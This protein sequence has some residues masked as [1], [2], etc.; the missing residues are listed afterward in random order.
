MAL[1]FA[2]VAGGCSGTA[3]PMSGTAPRH[4]TISGPP[5]VT[6]D[7]GT[8]T[9]AADAVP[10]TLNDHTV[11]GDTPATR[12]VG[13]L[14]W[15]QVFQVAPGVT[16]KLDTAVVD[17]AEVVSVSPQ[18]VVYHIDPRA[19]WSDGVPISAQ[20]FVYAWLAQ[21]GSGQDVGGA[22]DSVAS[23][24]G[25][26]D[27]ASVVGSDGGRTVTV[28]FQR[29]YADWMSLFDDLLPAHVAD[30]AGWNSGFDS[31]DPSVLVSGGPFVVQAWNP[32]QSIVLARNPRWWGT[33]AKLDE[34]VVRALPG[35]PS[36]AQALMTGQAQ[37]A[38]PGG[39]GADLEATV[40]SSPTLESKLSLGT[41]ILQLV[42]DVHRA[43]LDEATV[44]QGIAHALDRA[45]IASAL[46][47]PL[48]P[49]TWEANDHLFANTEPWYSDDAAGYEEPDPAAAAR[50]LAAGGLV[51]D[52]RG[53]WTLH[54]TP[55]DLHL[56][57]ATDDPWSALVAPAV[58][59]QLVD[60]GFEVS[61]EPTTSANLLGVVLPRGAFDLALVPL[62]TGA[63]PS[64]LAP[65]F[66]S[67][68]D[69]PAGSVTNWSGFDDPKIDALFA[70]AAEQLAAAQ[71]R[72]LYQQ[73]DSALWAAMP[74]V[75]L[76]AEPDLL[77]WTTSL[78]HVQDDPGGLRPLWS[79]STWA[80]LGPAAPRTAASHSHR[81]AQRPRT[82]G[83]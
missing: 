40:S 51:A 74:T 44:R 21:R 46:V 28:V 81:S 30:K 20:D 39:F 23:T 83:R 42:F 49:L 48:S 9:V 33:P 55:V 16:P 68:P 29:P 8:V 77:V 10:T 57:W 14:L 61:A 53:S 47:Q 35:A 3:V 13:S 66:G 6:V 79:A 24:A 56:A 54:G 19:Q 18:T 78:T 12:A 71:A 75:P 73:I 41:T 62:P 63:F 22:T 43:P 80:M 52:A 64:H 27:I 60:A 76:F 45:A 31:F 37:V 11:T 72:Q 69:T 4:T 34:I 1:A 32:G 26:R 50:A 5:L 65:A 25:Y 36:V 67:P 58:V 59:A 70:Q 38:A 15:P 82:T 2:V 7:G 17:D